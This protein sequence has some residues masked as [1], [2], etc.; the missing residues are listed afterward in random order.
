[1]TTLMNTDLVK[2]SDM[3]SAMLESE[4]A[5]LIWNI[6]SEEFAAS[7][8]NFASSLSVWPGTLSFHGESVHD[9]QKLSTGHQA[10]APGVE[11]FCRLVMGRSVW[12]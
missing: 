1:M 11:I 12:R 4:Y 3:I 9:R 5:P 7:E 2:R 6:Q 8:I 10:A